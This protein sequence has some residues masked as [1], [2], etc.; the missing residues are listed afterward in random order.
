MNKLFFFICA[1]IPAIIWAQPSDTEITNKLKSDGALEVKFF[2]AKGTVHTTL[3][4][5]YYL[6]TA[7]SKWKTDKP[8]IYTWSRSDYR[9]D[10]SGGK[11]TYTRTY[12]SDS[13]YEGIPNPSETEVLKLINSDIDK[14]FM[15]AGEIISYE[16]I[17]L[18]EKP[19]WS[20]ES[21]KSA[22]CNTEVIYI[23]KTDAIGNAKKIKEIRRVNMY[24][25]SEDK[26][27]SFVRLIGTRDN[28]SEAVLIENVKYEVEKDESPFA[29][30]QSQEAA[31]EKQLESMYEKFQ[32][33]DL[34]TVNWNGQ[35][36][37]F[38]NGKVLKKD[39]YNENRYFIEFDEIQ[40]TWIEAKF[41]RKRNTPSL[42]D[43]QNETNTL[44]GELKIGDKVSA[45]WKG[46]G[47]WFFGKIIAKDPLKKDKYLIKYDDGDQEWTTSDKIKKP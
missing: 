30:Y 28:T 2:S 29:K 39:D 38:Y 18:A 6:R 47:K 10:Y 9:Y 21:L 36:K 19:K 13:W 17:K 16:N 22:S 4:E 35:G 15:G 8:G 5:K 25:D 37:D 46:T 23:V 45:N 44:N 14:Y 34:V 40:S 11:W 41:I 1:L 32:I 26:N 3:T 20:W 42:S 27:A 33:N 12:F 24:K 7:E 43:T 31:E